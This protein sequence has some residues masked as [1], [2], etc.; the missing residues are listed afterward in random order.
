MSWRLE[1]YTVDELNNG[2]KEGKIEI[3]KFQ[4]GKRW[5]KKQKEI[6]IDSMVKGF[7]FG[8]MLLYE[9]SDNNTRQIIDGLQRSTTII[10][11]VKNPADFFSDD[12]INEEALN[13]I[14]NVLDVVSNEEAIKEKIKKIMREWI[15]NGHNSMQDISRMQYNRVA[16][17]I[18]E[19]FPNAKNKVDEVE[20]IISEPLKNF[21]DIC[22]NIGNVTIP[23]LI[24]EGKKELLPEIFERIN[25][26]G[27]K[28]TKQEIYA[29]AWVNDLVKISSQEFDEI[30]T[31]N[32]DRYDNVLD[33]SMELDDYDSAKFN[34]ERKVNIFEL[35]FGFGKMI[36][37]RYP[38]LF[39]YDD[40]DKTKVESIGFNLVNACLC[41][42][43]NEMRKLNVNLKELIGLETENVELFLKKILEAIDYVDK[44]LSKGIKFKSNQRDSSKISPLHTELQIVSIIASVFIARHAKFRISDR[45]EIENIIIDCKNFNYSWKDLKEKFSK[46]VLKIY[47]IDLL[48]QKWKGSGDKKLDNVILDNNYYTREISWDEFE[49]NLDIFYNN[50]NNERNERIKISAP[51][52]PEKLILNLIYSSIFTAA[53]QTDESNYDIEHLATKNIMKEKICSYSE[54][55]KLPVSSIGNLC[56]LPEYENR[57]KK[58]KT[59]YDD[60]TYIKSV[61]NINELERK[62]TFTIK[63]DLAWLEDDLDE[64]QFKE[65]YYKF[66]D[67]RFKKMKSKVKEN[68]FKS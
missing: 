11:F 4:R 26:Q 15:I 52:E 23:A 7:P 14:V 28:L 41:Q 55:F 5:G 2:I 36:S 58:D 47:T 65:A 35:I 19:E 53:D 9:N 39:N 18:V 6:L 63:S 45:G 49:Q 27:S 30:I 50:I 3:P 43:N 56:L 64:Q 38:H 8:S 16:R 61:K 10:E 54:D 57:M 21:Q 42:K 31:N 60:T 1:Q 59:I 66:L 13:K 32:R 68:L 12:Y 67:T 25:S 20:E 24:Y 44:R 17:K 51:K 33:E 46:N 62:F 22:N 40:S 37:R 29:A 48:A 34:R